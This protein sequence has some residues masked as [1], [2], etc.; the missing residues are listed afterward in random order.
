MDGWML[1]L[2]YGLAG[3]HT[4]RYPLEFACSTRVCGGGGKSPTTAFV[5]RPVLTCFSYHVGFD[6]LVIKKYS[7]K[8]FFFF[9]KEEK[10]TAPTSNNVQ[11][12]QA[13]ACVM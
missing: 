12:L 7:N 3:R 6:P 13:K 1:L 8:S 5:F 2:M 11:R 9:K 10:K 4:S